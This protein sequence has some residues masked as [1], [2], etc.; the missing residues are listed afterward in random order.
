MITIEL[1][2]NHNLTIVNFT[3]LKINKAAARAQ[4]FERVFRWNPS[5]S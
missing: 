5:G 1:Y 3:S 4:D 2:D